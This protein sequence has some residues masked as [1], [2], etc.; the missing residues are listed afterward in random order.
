MPS[1]R[2]AARQGRESPIRVAAILVDGASAR[3]QRDSFVEPNLR[4]RGG[5]KVA[6]ELEA[7]IEIGWLL[8]EEAGAYLDRVTQVLVPNAAHPCTRRR[9]QKVRG[10]ERTT[11]VEHANQR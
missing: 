7:I 5:R 1:V 9:L 2:L 8:S 11:I 10:G 6:A 4:R 3:V